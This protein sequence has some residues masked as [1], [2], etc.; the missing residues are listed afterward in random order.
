MHQQW[1]ILSKILGGGIPK[2]HKYATLI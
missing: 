1:Q 2:F